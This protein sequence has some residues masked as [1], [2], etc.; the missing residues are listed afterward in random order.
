[1]VTFRLYAADTGGEALWSETKSVD[2]TGGLFG[3]ALGDTSAFPAALLFDRPYYLGVS[4]GSD[5]EMTPRLPLR[6]VPYALAPAGASPNP[7]AALG[8]PLAGLAAP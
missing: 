5:P 3:T 4:V 1:P 8:S 6:G 7:A 2:V